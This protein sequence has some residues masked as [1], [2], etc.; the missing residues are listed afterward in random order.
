MS[1]ALNQQL[2][3]L[4]AVLQ[5]QERARLAAREEL[6]F[7]FVN[8]TIQAVAY[9]QA[10]LWDARG[11]RVVALSGA[12]RPEPGAP[13]VT[14]LERLC[15]RIAA[16]GSARDI[17]TPVP[18]TGRYGVGRVSRAPGVVVSPAWS[19]SWRRAC[20]WRGRIP[21]PMAT[22]SFSRRFAALTR[23]AGN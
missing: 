4:A 13:Y 6:G 21:G 1:G 12:A 9:D 16:S 5:L 18:G 3:R 8:E 2:L 10:A 23:R 14:F 7:I 17:H 22:A 20:C 11:P 19:A 15:R